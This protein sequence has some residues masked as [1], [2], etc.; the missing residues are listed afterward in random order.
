MKLVRYLLSVYMGITSLLLEASD[1]DEPKEAWVAYATSN[2]FSLLELTIASIHEFSSRPIVAVGV[3]ADVPFSLQMYP[4][5]IKKRIDVDLENR[6]AYV[7]KPQAILAADLDYGV[8]IDA[9]A[10]LNKGCDELF[11]YCYL[12]ENHPLCPM[13]TTDAWVWEE[14]MNYFKVAKRSMHYVHADLIVFSRECNPFIVEWDRMCMEHYHLGV[15]CFDE[16]L[17]NVNLWKVGAIRR[18][19][20][21][22]PLDMYF[23]T[24]LHLDP[25][26]MQRFPY[27]Q[28]YLFH[29]NKD[30]DFGWQMFRQLKE[31]HRSS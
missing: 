28:W 2:Y 31:K 13:H 21:C 4:R 1:Y 23:D 25:S 5:L 20:L 19:P 15:P 14:A 7:Y 6:K 22:D 18:L 24:Y 17:L 29:G 27:N 26:D 30:A 16:T 10:I 3:N 12:V 9:D 11:T 8:Y